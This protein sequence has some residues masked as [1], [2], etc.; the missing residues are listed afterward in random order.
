MNETENFATIVKTFNTFL[1]I[2]KNMKLKI[3]I[4]YLIFVLLI[5]FLAFFSSHLVSKTDKE[6]SANIVWNINN[7]KPNTVDV[8]IVGPSTSRYG[9]N[10]LVAW[11]RY[12]ITTL[13]CSFGY[14]SGPIVKNFII[15]CLKRQ[16]PKVILINVDAFLYQNKGYMDGDFSTGF[17]NLS[18]NVFPELKWSLNKLITLK[19]LTKYYKTDTKEFF[20][21]LFPIFS[22][23]KLSLDYILNRDKKLYLAAKDKKFFKRENI[24]VD[25]NPN[26]LQ[27]HF[28]NEVYTIEA[29]EDLF[30]FCKKSDIPV[31]FLGVPQPAL[32]IN[33]YN[34]VSNKYNLF[35]S[36]LKKYNFKYIH[37]ND[38]HTFKS[39]KLSLQDTYDGYHL[40][41]WGSVKYT[42]Y[43]AK[44]LADKYNIPDKRKNPEYNF[45]NE[46]S[47]E[48]IDYVKENFNIDISL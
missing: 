12:G 24:S 45:W 21:F 8:L 18:Y 15:E 19:N 23:H 47:Q 13:N 30:E 31:L 32:L 36:I 43:I 29:L 2:S 48:Y 46:S 38:Y 4:V 33:F 35:F 6:S 42:N 1:Y 40:N 16:S 3:I 22:T 39:L 27:Q 10:P 20:Y 25:L 14:L 44:I 5:I 28:K 26:I 9:Y 41:Y 17:K 34:I 37:A 11:N 7:M